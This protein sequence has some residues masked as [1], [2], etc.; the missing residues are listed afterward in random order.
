MGHRPASL[1]RWTIEARRSGRRNR[2]ALACWCRLGVVALE[3]VDGDGPVVV[4][5]AAEM[6]RVAVS[7]RLA[8]GAV[9]GM[10]GNTTLDVVACRALAVMHDHCAVGQQEARVEADHHRAVLVAVPGDQAGETRRRADAVLDYL[11]G[12]DDGRWTEQRRQQ[13]RGGPDDTGRAAPRARPTLEQ[14]RYRAACD[15][16]E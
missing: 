8:V 6:V 11:R 1:R 4:A 5:T 16:T 7:N 10:A 13:H 15:P 2:A 12:G 3:A 9:D 14:P